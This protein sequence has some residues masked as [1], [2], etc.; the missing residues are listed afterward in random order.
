MGEA[1]QVHDVCVSPSLSRLDITSESVVPSVAQ[2]HRTDHSSRALISH[3]PLHQ[4]AEGL[5]LQLVLAA[6][7]YEGLRG[8]EGLTLLHS[9][10]M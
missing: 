6:Y 3:E 2:R 8:Q 1:E 7:S 5:Q 9:T 10:F 4:T